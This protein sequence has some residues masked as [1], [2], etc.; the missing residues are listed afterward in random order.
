MFHLPWACEPLSNW[1][2]KPRCWWRCLQ[3][4][5]YRM[6]ISSGK[7]PRKIPSH[8]QNLAQP[9]STVGRCGD[10]RKKRRTR[11]TQVDRHEPNLWWSCTKHSNSRAKKGQHCYHCQHK[12]N[13]KHQVLQRVGNI[14]VLHKLHN[15]HEHRIANEIKTC[16][17]KANQDYS[18]FIQVKQQWYVQAQQIL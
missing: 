5:K 9:V 6:M 11:Y 2:T 1:E 8:L 12:A 3:F 13:Y 17:S 14:I 18:I 10:K 15:D 7:N 4:E 16:D